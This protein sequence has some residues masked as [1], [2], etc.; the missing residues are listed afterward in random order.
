MKPSTRAQLDAFSRACKWIM[1]HPLD[2]HRFNRFICTAYR[3]GDTS[4]SRDELREAVGRS[5]IDEWTLRY[6]QGME[7]L[8]V[9]RTLTVEMLGI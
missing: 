6:E 2:I 3:N 7:L 5:D 4:I 8:R 1:P 9:D